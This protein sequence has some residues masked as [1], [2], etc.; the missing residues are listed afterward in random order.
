MRFVIIKTLRV[1]VLK[2]RLKVGARAVII[3]LRECGATAYE[4][5]GEPPRLI[6]S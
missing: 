2:R 4:R 1:K 3:L 5:R 6:L